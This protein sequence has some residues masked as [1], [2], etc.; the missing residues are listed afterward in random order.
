MHAVLLGGG[1]STAV[2]AGE[3]EG[4]TLSH[5]FV[6]LNLA[7]AAL[8]DGTVELSL[9]RTPVAGV[10]RY[11]L[12]VWVTRRGGLRPLQATGGWLE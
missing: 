8:R 2:R 7:A 5:E 1:I 4:R 11:A 10:T 9:P 6:A 3:N 12:A